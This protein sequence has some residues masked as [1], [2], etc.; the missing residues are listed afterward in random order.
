MKVC[1]ASA[2]NTQTQ[3]QTQ[4]I[5]LSR[6]LSL[7][8]SRSLM[9]VCS[10]EPALHCDQQLEDEDSE[11]ISTLDG[12]LRIAVRVYMVRNTKAPGGHER[13]RHARA[14]VP[15]SR[16][17]Q[18]SMAPCICLSF[19]T[20]SYAQSTQITLSTS[21]DLSRPLY[22][23]L[24][25]PPVRLRC[26]GVHCCRKWCTTSDGISSTSPH[27]AAVARSMRAGTSCRFAARCGCTLWRRWWWWWPS[28]PYPSFSSYP[29]FP[30]THH[31]L[32]ACALVV[33]AVVWQRIRLFDARTTCNLHNQFAQTL[34]SSTKSFHTICAINKHK[35]RCCFLAA[36]LMRNVERRGEGLN[37]VVVLFSFCST[38]SCPFSQHPC[39]TSPGLFLLS[40]VCLPPTHAQCT[41]ANLAEQI[42][43]AR[44]MPS[45]ASPTP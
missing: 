45:T 26:V 8:L 1:H 35:A 32:C 40:C 6:P 39:P 12:V 11:D 42:S 23:C 41:A 44:G 33:V 16:S 19:S 25:S 2:V 18:F 36:R 37:R 38:S 9:H 30:L 20:R 29:S 21:L 27:A 10:H 4:C 7:D 34:T 28:P 43:F 14:S 22:V 15:A 31:T 5:A 13:S 3:T 17:M 24:L